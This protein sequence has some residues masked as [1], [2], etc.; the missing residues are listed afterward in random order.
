[1]GSTLFEL[2]SLWSRVQFPHSET[3]ERDELPNVLRLLSPLW[4]GLVQP[5]LRPDGNV[6]VCDWSASNNFVYPTY[7][8]VQ[9][10][11]QS[12]SDV[13]KKH[14]LKATDICTMFWQECFCLYLHSTW[15]QD[16]KKTYKNTA[17]LL[18]DYYSCRVILW[19]EPNIEPSSGMNQTL[20][21]PATR[22]QRCCLVGTP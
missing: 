4:L 15:T 13:M 22:Q 3:E 19:N 5:N 12:I 14:Y 9:E 6:P 17:F 20:N 2:L 16:K 18:Q 11:V 1:M 8:Y 10:F 7:N 21:H